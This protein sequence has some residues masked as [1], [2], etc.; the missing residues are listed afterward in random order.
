MKNSILLTILAGLLSAANAVEWND[1]NV[2][3]VNREE[4]RATMMVYPT[5]KAALKYDRTTSPYFQSLNGEWKF[6]WARSPKDRPA[7]FFKS[8]FDVS[9]WDSIPVPANWEME[10]HGLKIYTNIKYPFKTDPPNAPT[11]WNP[12]GS[13]RRTFEVS[14]DWDGRETYIVFDGVQSA[15]YLWINGQKVGYSQGSRTP[16]EFNITQYLKPGKNVLAAEVYRWCDGSYLEDQDFWRLSGIY[17]DV[18]LWSTPKAHI[19]DFTVITD[20]DED[21]NNAVLKLTAEILNPAGSIEVTLLDFCGKEIGRDGSPSRPSVSLAIP[22][23]APAKWTAETPT[24]YTAL[25]SLKDAAGK[26]VEVIPQRIGFREAAIINSRFCINGVPVLIKGVNRHEHHADTG[27]TIDRASM[28]RDIQLLKENNFNAV[29][30]CHYP[31]MPMWYELCDEYGIML[32]DEGNIESHGMGYGDASLAKQPEW[33]E[34]HV[35]RVQRMVGRDKNHPSVITWSIGNEAGDGVNIKACY[36]WIKEADPTR[37]VHYERTEEDRENTD[38]I[39]GMYNS[40]DRIRKY[41]ESEWKKPFIICEY[42]HAM[43]NSNGGAKEYWDLFYED[44]TAQGGFVWDWMDQG[45]RMPV[46]D[47]FKTN[48]GKGPVK[49]TFFAYGGWFEDPAGVRTDGNFCMNGLIDAGQIPHPGTYAMKYLQRNVHVSPV[50]LKT[51]RITIKNWF[52][53]TR[54]SDAVSGRWKIESNGKLIFEGFVTDLDIDPHAEK[55][56]ALNLPKIVPEAG[57]EY[58]LTVEFHAK[59]N[60]HPLVR[61]GHLLAWDQFK[62]PL[63]KPVAYAAARGT[64]AVHQSTKAITVTGKGFEVIFDKKNGM[65]AAYK[66]NGKPL[67]VAGGAPEISR[68]LVNNDLGKNP[69]VHP[70]L[71]TAGTEAILESISVEQSGG[72]AKIS[73]RKVLPTVHGGFGAVYTIYPSGEMVVEGAFDFSHMPGLVGP[74]LRAGMQWKLAGALENME[75]FGRGGETY[76]DRNFEPV[77]RYA[78]TVDSLWTDYSRP[79][80]NG[81]KT[82]IRWAA[83]CDDNGHGLLVAA[84]GAPL[85]IDARYY[86]PD[87]MRFAK[88]SFQ[89]ERSENIYLHIDAAQSGVGGINSWKTPPLEKYRLND[90]SYTYAYRLIPFKGS[91]DATLAKRAPFKASDVAALAVPDVSRLPE[92]KRPK[93]KKVAGR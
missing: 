24:L 21:Y 89:M 85:G 29:R 74:P 16:A 84:A 43:G 66:V 9:G 37:P 51:G 45:I 62:L 12:V 25:I 1:L 90:D 42:M 56:V 61:E 8:E 57:K 60:Y 20:L 83:F 4:P 18:Y 36:Q 69:K 76:S 15:F 77:G 7:G 39:N 73:V 14:S 35:D 72:I 92:I 17:R 58:F 70:A 2:L 6:N 50:D 33:K 32:W 80:E 63:E 79:Q 78:G 10:G 3:Q 54:L 13:Y 44:N 93:K 41:T 68:A 19:R 31:S 55:P 28:I 11:E 75:W 71:H 27:H 64:V 48:I 47:E 22:V 38:I 26:T 81:S 49:E 91:V 67:I 34:A 46:P 30:T 52:D 88:Y 5:E 87:T 82:G 53:S 23:R 40:A 65:L 59:K 86:S